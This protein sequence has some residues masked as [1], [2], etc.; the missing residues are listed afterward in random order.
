MS[1]DIWYEEELLPPAQIAT[2]TSKML[3]GMKLDT[4]AQEKGLDIA[5]LAQDKGG[6]LERFTREK[7][8]ENLRVHTPRARQ[9]TPEEAGQLPGSPGGL[10]EPGKLA[11]GPLFLVRLG[12]EL[13]VDPVGQE[14]DWS[15]RQAW[16]RANLFAA[17]GEVQP[18]LLD[19]Y[20]QRIYEGQ[21]MTVQVKAEPTLKVEKTV[22][23]SL[24]SI[25]TDLRLGQVTPV[26]LGFFGEEERK[27]Y[28][29]LREEEKPIRGVYHFWFLVEQPPGCE[30]IHL[31][32][33]GEGDL[34]TTLFTI[35]V[36]PKVRKWEKRK[37]IRLVDILA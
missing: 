4:L 11:Q 32:M 7:A 16:C 3:Q 35:P 22:E 10:L 31:A 13:D 24:G 17:K 9:L 20:P 6:V 5:A 14:A 1:E 29:E 21:P 23:A 26:T 37:D 28:W 36:G 19:I 8:K 33:L 34:R 18:R 30:D 15:Y 27:P 12:M 25:S 2:D